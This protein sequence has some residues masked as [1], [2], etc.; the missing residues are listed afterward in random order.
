MFHRMTSIKDCFY[1]SDRKPAKLPDFQASLGFAKL[2][3]EFLAKVN[4]YEYLKTIGENLIN[5]KNKIPMVLL[6]YMN[7]GEMYQ[8]YMNFQPTQ[9]PV[10]A[11]GFDDETEKRLDKLIDLGHK[12]APVKVPLTKQTLTHPP[13][14]NKETNFVSLQVQ[15]SMN[16]ST[17]FTASSFTYEKN[18]KTDASRV[19][20]M[21]FAEVPMVFPPVNHRQIYH[22]R[23]NTDSKN[24]D[25]FVVSM[26]KK[27]LNDWSTQQFIMIPYSVKTNDYTGGTVEMVNPIVTSYEP[28]TMSQKQLLG[29]SIART[30]NVMDWIAAFNVVSVSIL[31]WFEWIFS[32]VKN[33]TM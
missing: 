8:Y 5:K 26:P 29:N 31:I 15:M 10:F 3:L 23:F 24:E 7:R 14:K 11:N 30:V 12:A 9:K 19:N 2:S 20:N 17:L 6:G 27:Q 13:N 25:S 16:V 18:L 21:I 32:T 28:Y 4:R 1:R 33:L 22:E